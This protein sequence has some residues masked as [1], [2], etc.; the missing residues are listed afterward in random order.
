M[1]NIRLP[2]VAR[3]ASFFGSLMLV[4]F[5]VFMLV[6]VPRVSSALDEYSSSSNL[7]LASARAAQLGALVDKLTT[8]LKPIAESPQALS[9]DI[10]G[11][12][13]FIDGL[14]DVKPTEIDSMNYFDSTGTLISAAGRGANISD[15][16]YFVK[17]V[18]E[19]LDSAIG[20]PVI[21][22][23]IGV[24]VFVMARAVAAAG[25]RAMIA[26]QVR[27]E[28]LSKVAGDIRVGSTGYGW[29]VDG[30][31][32]VLA[33]E[34]KGLI[35]KQNVL[36]SAK[37]GYSGYDGLG[38]AMLA[39]ESGSASW[40]GPDGIAMT[41]YFARIPSTPGWSLGISV[42]SREVSRV[43]D[44]LVV[45]LVILVA[46]GIV[47][48]IGLSI[49]IAGAIARPLKLAAGEFRS[50]AEG[51]ADLTAA[52]AMD[53][54]DEI[55]DLVRDFNAFLG[56]L[57]EV[58]GSMKGA[59]GQLAAI[60][61]EL[62]ADSARTSEAA[63]LIA[64]RTES[65]R[66]RVESQAASVSES[67]SAVEQI[68]KNIENLDRL[69]ST[70]SVGISEASASIEQMVHN[71][72]SI[73]ASSEKMAAEFEELSSAARDGRESLSASVER[74]NHIGERSGALDEANRAISSIASQT[75]L[76]AMN[77]AIEAAHAGEA[78]RGFSVVAD[79]I[80]KL[81]ETS[82]GQSKA[83]SQEIALMRRAIEE[84]TESIRLTEAAF[85]GVD[86]RIAE[87]ER[88]VAEVR[89]AIAEQKEGSSQILEALKG[90]NEVTQ[91]VREGSAEM[92][93]GNVMILEE[94]N[95]LRD[96][97]RELADGMK[98]VAEGGRMIL[99]SAE[100]VAGVA[101]RTRSTIAD[102]DS[103][104]GRFRV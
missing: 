74:I 3:I 75:N 85:V 91:Q 70:Q 54:A 66:S 13:G 18:V 90:M 101:E 95:R 15:R 50:L 21:S 19:G 89:Q 72:A 63:A 99:E 76:L 25:G 103:A 27:L 56:K 87:T 40:K 17:T 28:D 7:A 69:I 6:L 14:K 59:Q 33:H 24:P 41:T 8:F 82:A 9:G 47:A 35:M 10:A 73:S 80:R 49:L 68:A 102:M 94:M 96:G 20:S 23:T 22:R 53:R 97:A 92:N 45:L 26:A 62:G 12:V 31:G 39:R 60:G 5:G 55:G 48:S 1:A 52:I 34:D 42:Q 79:E 104:V 29:I 44:G 98:D 43:R 64:E 78:G 67:S 2:L 81:S 30:A 88:L 93:S 37:D 77:A 58:V 4:M 36:E 61:R 71:I 57:R 32:L 100:S 51:D 16:D 84:I 11:I 38:K 65:S 86:G 83:I 46:A